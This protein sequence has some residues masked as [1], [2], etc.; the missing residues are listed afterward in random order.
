M[1]RTETD[2][3]EVKTYLPRYQKERWREDADALDMSMSEFVR[4]MVQAGRRGFDLTEENASD[5]VT[6]TRRQGDLDPEHP[7]GDHL[8]EGVL[9]AIEESPKTFDDL[10]GIVMGDLEDRIA[11]SLDSLMKDDLVVFDHRNHEYRIADE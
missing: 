4:S 3:T 7:G 2:R 8:D 11:D 5:H 1:A 9:D 6:P 10:T